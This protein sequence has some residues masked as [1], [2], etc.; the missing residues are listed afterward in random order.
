MC[1]TDIQERPLKW[2]MMN[3]RLSRKFLLIVVG[4]RTQGDERHQVIQSSIA[5][6]ESVC[7]FIAHRRIQLWYDV[8]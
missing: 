8:D 1:R 2:Y 4:N 7:L 5:F 6:A 3:I